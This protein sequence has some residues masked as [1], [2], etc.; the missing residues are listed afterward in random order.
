MPRWSESPG[1]HGLSLAQDPEE[2][3]LTVTFFADQRPTSRLLIAERTALLVD[4]ETSELAGYV[5]PMSLVEQL[6][7]RFGDSRERPT[8]RRATGRTAGNDSAPVVGYEASTTDAY[9]VFAE[10][11]AG[12]A[13]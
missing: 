10:D 4:R 3:T 8:A 2:A 7:G 5:L 6:V 12:V 1:E 9:A 13:A 11:L